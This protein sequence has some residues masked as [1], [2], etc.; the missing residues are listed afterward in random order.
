MRSKIVSNS[1]IV[2]FD[3]IPCKVE[4]I[5]DNEI[6]YQKKNDLEIPVES[7]KKVSTLIKSLKKKADSIASEI[8]EIKSTAA[9]NKNKMK[10]SKIGLKA[11]IG[12]QA[13]G[14]N[15]IALIVECGVNASLEISLEWSNADKK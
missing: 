4:V 14:G 1:Q 13:K 10:L 6:I 8:G 7:W 11:G 5:D 9:S 3:G 15:V 12:F 2:D